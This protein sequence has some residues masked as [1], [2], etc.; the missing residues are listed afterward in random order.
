VLRPTRKDC[1]N[2]SVLLRYS[3]TPEISVRKAS[4]HQVL[5]AAKYFSML[6]RREQK[7]NG[8]G[9]KIHGAGKAARTNEQ[10]IDNPVSKFCS[11]TLNL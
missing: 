3:A 10:R 7:K 5:Y 2:E 6:G 9:K 1:A 11:V 8:E 4:Q